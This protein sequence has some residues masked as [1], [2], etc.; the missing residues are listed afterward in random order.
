M[1]KVFKAIATVVGVC[2]GALLAKLTYDIIRDK[3]RMEEY[4]QEFF[5]DMEDDFTMVSP[6]TSD[7]T[8]SAPKTADTSAKDDVKSESTQAKTAAKKSETKPST[9]KKAKSDDSKGIT[10]QDVIDCTAN[11]LGVSAEDILS[12]SRKGDVANARRVA[13]YLC[14]TNLDVTN[15]TICEEFGGIG[16]TSVSNAKKNI[17]AKIKEDDELAADIEDITDE[18]KQ[19]EK[20]FAR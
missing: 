2:A 15:A 18:L 17:A 10:C 5:S 7:N 1:K 9:T 13:I 12:K 6:V 14:A 20:S 16:S 11:V 4:D 19:L 3:K 8:V